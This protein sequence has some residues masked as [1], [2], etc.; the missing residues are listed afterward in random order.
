[1]TYISSSNFEFSW[2]SNNNSIGKYRVVNNHSR[3]SYGTRKRYFTLKFSISGNHLLCSR[4]PGPSSQDPIVIRLWTVN[5]E[6]LLTCLS[7]HYL[8]PYSPPILRFTASSRFIVSHRIVSCRTVCK[9][10]TFV[11]NM[12]LRLPL[13]SDTGFV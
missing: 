10:A 12:V 11:L 13:F 1:M 3:A 5:S 7:L 2:C 4:I 9:I 6:V 8:S